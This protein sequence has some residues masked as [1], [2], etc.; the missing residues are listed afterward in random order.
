MDTTVL[1]RPLAA[2]L[3]V[4]VAVSVGVSSAAAAPLPPAS[5]TDRVAIVT[6][7]LL[8]GFSAADVRDPSDMDVFVKRVLNLVRYLPDVLLLQE[9]NSRSAR[10][11]A[12]EFTR[13]TNQTYA[14]IADAGDKAY[15]ETDTRTTKRDTAIVINTELMSTAGRS[16]YI[17][18]QTD[19]GGNS[20]IEYK[21]N[22]R[23]LVSETGGTLR[24]GLASIHV[25]PNNITRT[26]TAL[27]TKLDKAYPSAAPEQFE[28]LGGDFNQVGVEYLSYG[29]VKT[30]PFWDNLTK[31]FDYVDSIYNVRVGKGVDYVFVR[32]GV[33]GAGIDSNYDDRTS[34]SSPSFYSDHK[35]RWAIVGPDEEIPTT[36]ANVVAN[37]RQTGEARMKITWDASSDNAGIASYDVFRSVDGDTFS[38][39]GTTQN[40][41][42]YDETVRSGKRYWYY[43]RAR[44]FSDNRSTP[45]AVVS[46]TA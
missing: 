21:Y 44:D 33:W 40:L 15:R 38:M 10:Y 12:A 45:T 25:P 29:Q 22:A 1:R 14:V 17:I 30:H 31:R 3:A 7:N 43:V 26:S 42:Y 9:V 28:V 37:A 36:P 11:V 2:G 39:H 34:E 35:F 8:E 16:G 19:R 5:P 24:L 4:L 6:A 46:D 23:S 27:A 32:G 18:T 41:T 13:R 20:K